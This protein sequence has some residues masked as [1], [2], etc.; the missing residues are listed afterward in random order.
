MS[1]IK[2]SKNEK[3]TDLSFE[4]DF[5]STSLL[6][7]PTFFRT[8]TEIFRKMEKEEKRKKKKEKEKK[9]EKKKGKKGKIGETSFFFFFFFFF[10]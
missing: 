7:M 8:I 3:L 6:D 1:L 9:K 5:E 4:S 10:F 2:Y